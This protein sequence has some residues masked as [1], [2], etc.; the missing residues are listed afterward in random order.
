MSRI[1][2]EQKSNEPVFEN[3]ATL[4]LITTSTYHKGRIV[5]LS[6]LRSHTV[7]YNRMQSAVNTFQVDT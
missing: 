5:N 6:I 3:Q 1:L 2:A 4:L 7:V